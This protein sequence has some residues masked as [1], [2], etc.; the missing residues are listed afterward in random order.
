MKDAMSTMM[1]EE[2]KRW[3]AVR[4]TAFALEII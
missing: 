3:K 2:M 1:D 4:K